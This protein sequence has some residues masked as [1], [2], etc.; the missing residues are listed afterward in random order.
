MRADGESHRRASAL[1]ASGRSDRA[2]CVRRS[3]GRSA[4][5]SSTGGRGRHGRDPRR[6][7]SRIA[8]RGSDPPAVHTVIAGLGGRP[9]APRPRC[10]ALARR[11]RPSRG[12][13]FP[14]PQ[15]AGR[16]RASSAPMRRDAPTSARAA[17]STRR[18]PRAVAAEAMAE[19]D[20]MNEAQKLHST[21]RAPSR[22]ATACSR[23]RAHRA[24]SST[25][26]T[27]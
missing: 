18:D 8:L 9:I 17:E 21:R 14:G 11:R 1:N 24:G 19:A 5:S 6:R 20:A 15:R 26:L 7:T 23:A 27:R 22:S 16:G 10:T 3:T 13:A 2:S 12:V 4:S 25:A